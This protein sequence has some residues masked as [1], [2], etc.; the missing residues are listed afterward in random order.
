MAN[1]IHISESEPLVIA[2]QFEHA[3]GELQMILNSLSMYMDGVS[4]QWEG[5]ECDAFVARFDAFRANMMA[6]LDDCDALSSR[7]RKL[8]EALTVEE[9]DFF[10]DKLE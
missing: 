4:T 3:A 2:R 7:M 10:F 5:E 8:N 6:A 9:H 1:I